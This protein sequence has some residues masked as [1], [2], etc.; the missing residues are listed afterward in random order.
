MGNGLIYPEI[1][2]GLGITAFFTGKQVGIDKTKFALPYEPEPIL[3]M[4]VQKHTATVIVLR[5]GASVPNHTDDQ[6]IGDA[7]VTDRQDILAGVRTADC[8][9]IL[10]YDAAL[11]I[12]GAVHAGWRGTAQ[13]I[14]KAA[15]ETFITGFKSK[16]ENILIAIGPAIRGCCYV[17]GEEVV[18][19]VTSVTGAGDYTTIKNGAPYIDLVRANSAQ[20]LSLAIK[21]ANIWTSGSCTACDSAHF[22]SFRKEGTIRGSQGA[23]I[24]PGPRPHTQ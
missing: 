24:C 23:F 8:V 6:R 7:V 1:F 22:N 10:L 11:G 20:A 4:P 2:N 18:E 15:I 21:P 9:P 19:A 5:K 16:P 12:A 14:L 3:Y 13:G 17:V